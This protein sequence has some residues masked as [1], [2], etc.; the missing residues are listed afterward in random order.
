MTLNRL[1]QLAEAYG[2]DPKRWPVEDRAAL[3]ALVGQ[4]P[5]ARSILRDEQN[6]DRLLDGWRV[7]GADW[8]LERRI[9][10]TAAMASQVRVVGPWQRVVGWLETIWPSDRLP[11]GRRLWPQVA[12]LAAAAMIGFFVGIS[13][14]GTLDTAGASNFDETLTGSS[15]EGTWQ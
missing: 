6:L 13:D 7:D 9:L 3:E 8:A 14:F 5:A 10:A 1:Q 12:G 11:D 4:H 15:V 2:A